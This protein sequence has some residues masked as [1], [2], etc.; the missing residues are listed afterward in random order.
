M[1]NRSS[2]TAKGSSL[3]WEHK[4]V[5]MILAL[6]CVLIMMETISWQLVHF[7]L[8]E[9]KHHTS[10]LFLNP[11]NDDQAAWPCSF[12]LPLFMTIITGSSPPLKCVPF[13]LAGKRADEETKE[14]YLVIESLPSVLWLMNGWSGLKQTVKDFSLAC[15]GSKQWHSFLG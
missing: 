15:F 10:N 5:N 3:P 6:I 1:I 2:L 14:R 11:Q 4:S 12:G 8:S 7:W 13:S 9:R